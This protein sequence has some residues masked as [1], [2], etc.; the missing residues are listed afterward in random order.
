MLEQCLIS[1]QKTFETLKQDNIQTNDEIKLKWHQKL[2]FDWTFLKRNYS[3]WNFPRLILIIGVL[4]FSKISHGQEVVSEP[5]VWNINFLKY[6]IKS[7]D[8]FSTKTDIFLLLC[9]AIRTQNKH[10]SI[11]V[12]LINFLSLVSPLKRCWLRRVLDIPYLENNDQ[13]VNELTNPP[14]PPQLIPIIC[15]IHFLHFHP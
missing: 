11:K 1:T 8:N 13:S 14:P 7:I 3:S 10:R 5:M 12:R 4:S 15:F 2:P 9:R 6:Q